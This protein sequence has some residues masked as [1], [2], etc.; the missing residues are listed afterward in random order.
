MIDVLQPE[1]NETEQRFAR[2]F[3]P[4]RVLDELLDPA[5]SHERRAAI[6]DYLARN[7]DPRPGVGLDRNGL[8]HIVWCDVADGEVS[9]DIGGSVEGPFR[10]PPFRIARYPVTWIQYR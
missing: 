8:P 5:T 6:G 10:M 7:G 1:L 9:L 4:D 3:D 2:P